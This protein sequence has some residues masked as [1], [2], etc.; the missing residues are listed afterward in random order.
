MSRFGIRLEDFQ[1]FYDRSRRHKF[2]YFSLLWWVEL[3]GKIYGD[4]MYRCRFFR[5]ADGN[6]AWK[7]PGI[8]VRGSKYLTYKS[9]DVSPDLYRLVLEHLEKSPHGEY[10]S[11]ERTLPERERYVREDMPLDARKHRDIVSTQMET[12]RP[13]GYEPE[14][15]PDEVRE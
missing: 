1:W 7:P 11:D 8:P 13:P 5:G 14:E 3:G 15:A 12:T 6:L 9:H 2:I 4:K 10:L